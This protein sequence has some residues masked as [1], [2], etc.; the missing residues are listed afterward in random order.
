MNHDVHD[1]VST[2][3]TKSGVSAW[4]HHLVFYKACICPMIK[5]FHCYMKQI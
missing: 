4:L 3:F 5:S 2:T 1:M